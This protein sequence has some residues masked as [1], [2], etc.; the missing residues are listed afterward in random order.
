GPRPRGGEGAR[1]G[2]A[3]RGAGSGD[4]PGRGRRGEEAPRGRR[5][6]RGREGEAQG[7]IPVSAGEAEIVEEGTAEHLASLLVLEQPRARELP[8]LRALAEILGDALRGH[9]VCLA[10]VAGER[11]VR[12]LER[13]PARLVDRDRAPASDAG[14]LDVRVHR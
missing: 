3:V 5:G 13:R 1:R 12:A 8:R 2:R 7:V 6:E 9:A 10:P 14:Q 11:D 4:A